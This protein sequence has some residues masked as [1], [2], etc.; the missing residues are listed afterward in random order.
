MVG[1]LHTFDPSTI[2]PSAGM[3]AGA[4]GV[5]AAVDGN[6]RAASISWQAIEGNTVE[7]Y[8]QTEWQVVFRASV[9]LSRSHALT[10]SYFVA[11]RC[12]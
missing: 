12:Q 9:R 7:I 11:L 8:L 2:Y 3:A 10:E 4:N 1:P 6:F 5:S